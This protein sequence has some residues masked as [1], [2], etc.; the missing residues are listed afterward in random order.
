MT[1]TT[2]DRFGRIVVPAPLRERL[3]LRPGDALEIEVRGGR[4]VLSR[5]DVGAG[6]V[7]REG[8]PVWTGRPSGTVDLAA[9]VREARL[10]RTP[11]IERRGR[12]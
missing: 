1:H 11:R 4:L 8:W 5:E 2:L 9:L 7:V 10:G 6:I 3:G 12:S